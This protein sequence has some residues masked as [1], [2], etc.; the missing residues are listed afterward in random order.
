MI[1]ASITGSKV[2]SLAKMGIARGE[3]VW[4]K[5]IRCATC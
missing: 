3:Q 2:R 4:R 1:L 5:I